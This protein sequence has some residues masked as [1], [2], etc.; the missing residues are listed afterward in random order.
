MLGRERPIP[1][2]KDEIMSAPV[3][4]LLSLALAAVVLMLAAAWANA[5][6]WKPEHSIE[7]LVGT[8]AGGALDRTA[9]TMLRAIQGRRLLDQPAVILNKP[10]GSGAVALVYLAQHPGDAHYVMV[11]GQTLLTNHIMGRS[12][13][14]YTDF[15]PLAILAVEYISLSV[16]TDSP[17]RSA[18]EM[19]ERL[20]QDP[21]SFSVAV[22]TGVGSATQ[23]SFA[24]A[25]FA[26]GV[27]ARKLRQVTF[28]SGGESMTALLGGHVDA[29]SSP[30]SSVMEQLRAGRIRVVAVG[31]PRRLSGELA[32]VPTWTELGVNSAVDVW[33]GLAGPKG[34]STAQI[35]FW[36]GV[37]ARTV[38]DPE[39]VKELERSLSEDG[40]RNSAETLKHWRREYAEMKTLYTALG[41]AKP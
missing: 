39:W 9:R 2:A 32:E 1:R 15:T 30:V 11:S 31:A 17:V 22:G 10:G 6:G 40:Y 29:I 37:V 16:R 7:I 20:R 18:K 8:S 19:I 12:S 35:A 13:L 36:D 41:L 23:T 28:G 4:K 14:N 21:A 27:D 33:R 3:N 34:M 24:H 38:K 5:Q 25:M 26:A